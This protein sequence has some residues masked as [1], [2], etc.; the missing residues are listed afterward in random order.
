MVLFPEKNIPHS[1]A[2][3]RSKSI[4]SEDSLLSFCTMEANY[5]EAESQGNNFDYVVV[6]SGT[7][8]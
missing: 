3:L 4:T 5:N 8:M 7:V 1:T 6:Q 2:N